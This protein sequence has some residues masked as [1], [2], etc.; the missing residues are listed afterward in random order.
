MGRPQ[1]LV[2]VTKRNLDTD[3]LGRSTQV[4]VIVLL[5]SP[6]TPGYTRLEETFACS[7]FASS[8]PVDSGVDKC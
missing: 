1:Q 7:S 8:V 5:G 2:T 6:L 3:I 4:P